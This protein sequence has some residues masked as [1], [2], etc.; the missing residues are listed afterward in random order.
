MQRRRRSRGVAMIEATA[1]TVLLLTA[2]LGAIQ[3]VLYLHAELAA[4]SAAS[5]MARTYALT[6][7][8]ADAAADFADQIFTSFGFLRWTNDGCDVVVRMAE[9]RVSVTVPTV[10]PGAEFV[11]LTE[12]HA[13]GAYPLPGR[14]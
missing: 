4:H 1:G 2:A 3:I 8:H 7:S 9:C 10:L 14:S 13:T 11:G 12:R 5:H 6:R